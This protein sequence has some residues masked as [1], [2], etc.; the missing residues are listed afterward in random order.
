MGL[1][2]DQIIDLNLKL[3]GA[4][5]KAFTEEESLNLL[6]K[7]SLK[8][9]LNNIT[10]NTSSYEATVDKVVEY[11]I[12]QGKVLVLVIVALQRNPSS[13]QLRKICKDKLLELLLIDNPT[14]L[15]NDLLMLIGEPTVLSNDLLVSLAQALKTIT[16]IE[17]FEKIVLPAFI[18][19]LP[20]FDMDSDTLP[21]REQLC[22]SD[23]SDPA[24]WLILLDLF[25]N[26]WGRNSAGQLYIVLFVQNLKNVIQGS[27]QISLTQWLND[28][29]ESVRPV[30]Q[31]S[32]QKEQKIYPERPSDEALKKLQAYLVI[33]VEPAQTKYKYM[34][35][36]YVITRLGNE[37][38]FST[39]DDISLRVTLPKEIN[40][41]SQESPYYTLEQIQNCLPEWITEVM[42]WIGDRREQI[43]ENYNLD[44][45][46]LPKLPDILTVEFWLPLDQ[47]SVA[48]ESW[49]IY[50]LPHRNKELGRVLGE[51]FSVIVRSFDRLEEQESLDRL[52]G[53]L[54]DLVSH[55]Q[56]TVDVSSPIIR[57]LHLDDLTDKDGLK[58][59]LNKPCLS[60]SL[61]CPLCTADYMS[62]RKDLFN[63]ILEKGIPLVLW[64][65]SLD[66]TDVQKATFKQRMEKLLMDNTFN[67]LE[68]LFKK[69]KKERTE[70]NKLA[71]WCDEPERL[72]QL[73]KFRNLKKRRLRA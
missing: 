56:K 23:L 45:L 15:S 35:N 71:I 38:R 55:S 31:V 54:E 16:G 64:S 37:K 7:E 27:V 11:A 30:S 63:L 62:Q 26:N 34:V 60:L 3:N 52:E 73:K 50:S 59:H 49:E 53:N 65:R 2:D 1:T 22:N 17:N 8:T 48:V 61:T 46:S 9:Q 36:G 51:V 68:Q 20:D 29:P 19:T 5:G 57:N 33:I 58:Q 47:L 18:K 28:L 66:L 6:V 10:Q 24:K 39:I 72:K 67:Q 69:V 25:L 42:D 44:H 41:S 21:L 70:N 4:L 13:P 12:A 32:E 14:L 40:K 43:I